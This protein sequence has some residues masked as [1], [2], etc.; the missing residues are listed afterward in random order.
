MK[1]ARLTEVKHPLQYCPEPL[2]MKSLESLKM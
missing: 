1:A 2:G